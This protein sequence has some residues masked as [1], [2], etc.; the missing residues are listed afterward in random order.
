MKNQ[1]S[2]SLLEENDQPKW[3][4]NAVVY[5]IFPDRFK[6]SYKN[7]VEKGISLYKEKLKSNI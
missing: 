7:K 1:I 2:K 6:K 4:N 3:V 5:Q